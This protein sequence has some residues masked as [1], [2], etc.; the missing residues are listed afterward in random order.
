LYNSNE[1]IPQGW[2]KINDIYIEKVTK[3]F[4][5]SDLESG[6]VWYEPFSDLYSVKVTDESSSQYKNIKFDLCIFEVKIHF[7]FSYIFLFEGLSLLI[8]YF[9]VYEKDKLN[10]LLS[11]EK[12]EFNFKNEIVNETVLGLEVN[13]R[14]NLN[15][16]DNK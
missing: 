7:C 12:I 1:I 13:F 2:T 14:F 6:N 4:T 8:V 16:F 3:E 9:K 10:I 11:K 5:Q 15:K